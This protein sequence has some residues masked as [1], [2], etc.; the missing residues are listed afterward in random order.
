[1][2]DAARAIQ[3]FTAGRSREDL[4]SHEMLTFAVVRGFEIIGEAASQVSEAGRATSPELPWP[5]IVG[6]R[7][8]LIHAYFDVNLDRVW[9]TVQRD[10]PTLVKA[11]S[12][13]LEGHDTG[14]DEPE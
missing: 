14:E 6:M 11:L 4:G 10:L 12:K 2:L 7:H 9:D 5:L 8:R 1:M 13:A 3:R